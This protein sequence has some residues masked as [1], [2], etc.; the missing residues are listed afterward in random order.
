M[1][2]LE[3]QSGEFPGPLDEV[4]LWKTRLDKLHSINIQLDSPV[5]QDI[6]R[7][8]DEAN[9]TYAASFNNVRKDINKVRFVVEVLHV[10]LETVQSFLQLSHS[11]YIILFFLL[12]SSVGTCLQLSGSII[13]PFFRLLSNPK[14]FIL[15]HCWSSIK[16]H[17]PG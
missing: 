12:F 5:A 4:L 13:R 17:F 9:S 14:L 10:S 7:N 3:R 15:L 1:A 11:G 16:K 2:D 8:L 6:L